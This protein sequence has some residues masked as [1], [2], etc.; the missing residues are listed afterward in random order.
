MAFVHGKSTDFR[1]DNSGGTLTDIS[2]Y[3]DSVDFPQTVETA[4]TTTFGDSNKDYIVGLK[5]STISF[6]GKWDSALDAILAPILG[7]AASVS[8]QYGPAGSTVTNVKYTG[9]CFLTSYQVTGSV[10]DVVTFSAEAQVT[11]AVTRGTY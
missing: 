7:Q 10:G 1:V 4:E 6:S 8:F 9:E 2:A 11:G 3:C 5:D